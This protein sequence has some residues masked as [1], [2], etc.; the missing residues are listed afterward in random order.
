M[1]KIKKFYNY[2]KKQKWGQIFK[3][4]LLS[5]LLGKSR[6]YNSLK[7]WLNKYYKN[8]N[9]FIVQIGSNDGVTGDP[10]YQLALKN[11]RSMVLLVE[12]VPYLFEK[13][14]FNYPESKRFIFENV[15]INDGSK[16][17]FYFVNKNAVDE[18]EKLP[19]WYDQLGSFYK[20]NILKHLDG[21]L[22]SHIEEIDIDGI[23]LTE[24]FERNDVRS[25]DLLHIDTEGYDWK[26]L[27]QLDLNKYKPTIILLEHKHLR[28]EEKEEAIFLLNKGYRIFQFNGDYL[29]LKKERLKRSDA[30]ILKKRLIE[31]K[32][33]VR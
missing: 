16:Q 12:P 18:L 21:V 22:E 2:L 24:L 31:N 13:L 5:K 19:H 3:N 4:I 7:Y 20:E 10:I 6:E 27:S 9:S 23:S 33:P 17:T 32:Y 14:K 29:C 30:E 28:N 25:L 1:I 15:A 11:D 26:I 8:T